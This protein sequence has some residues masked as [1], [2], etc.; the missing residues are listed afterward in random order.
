MQENHR[1]RQDDS[2]I[3]ET[4]EPFTIMRAPLK[5]N[6]QIIS[7]VDYD[8]LLQGPANQPVSHLSAS[9]SGPESSEKFFEEFHVS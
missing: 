6:R 1:N 4:S 3:I 9:L 5:L 8:C 7:S 2:D